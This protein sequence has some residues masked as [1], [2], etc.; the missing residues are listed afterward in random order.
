[1]SPI[2]LG[3]VA[4]NRIVVVLLILLVCLVT[5]LL[6]KTRLARTV[7]GWFERVPL[8]QILGYTLTKG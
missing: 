4:L 3:G 2:T 1:M 5:G 8:G 7:A 6:I